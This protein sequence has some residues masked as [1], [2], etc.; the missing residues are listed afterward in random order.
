M[1]E[2]REDG[3]RGRAAGGP[4]RRTGRRAWL[5]AACAAVGLML[6][7][8]PT[9]GA[10]TY[11]VKQCHEGPSQPEGWTAAWYGSYL[12]YTTQCSSSASLGAS[13]DT[14]RQHPYGDYSTLTFTAAPDTAV[15]HVRA[16]REA[17]SYTDAPYG[18]PL[19]RL[20]GDDAALEQFG[21]GQLSGL[22]P[23]AGWL[24]R[25]LSAVSRVGL[26]VRCG[27]GPGG[28]CPTGNVS[29][30]L[31]SITWTMR[32]V[33]APVLSGVSGSLVTA[34][35]LHGRH[36]VS[37][38]ATDVGSGVYRVKLLEDGAVRQQ[39]VVD[40]NGGYCADADTSNDDPYE[41][42]KRA[43]CALTASGTWS[44]D[45]AA[46]SD[47]PHNLKVQFEDAAGNVTTVVN[48][49]VVAD[50]QPP[51][52][53]G[54]GV[55]GTAVEGQTLVCA[56]TVAGQSP[57]I[58]YGWWRTNAD[59]SGGVRIAGADATT[60]VLTPADIGRKV[61]CEVAATDLGGTTT[62]TSALTSGPF[63]D[64]RLVALAPPTVGAVTV[65]GDPVVGRQLT[66]QAATGGTAATVAV[67]WLRGAADGS[68]MAPIPGATGRAY[69]LVAADVGHR[70]GCVVTVQNAAGSAAG[71]S[72]P[73]D[74]GTVHSETVAKDGKDGR[75]GIGAEGTNRPVDTGG[76]TSTSSSGNDR[77][78]AQ[79]AATND[80]N[81]VP[82]VNPD[83]SGTNGTPVDPD[84]VLSVHFQLGAGGTR[85]TA[86]GATA[87][88][89]QR[90]RIRGTIRTH[91]G[92][93]IAGA[94]L[95]LAQTTGA[96]DRNGDPVWK[97]NGGTVSR[98]DGSIL[99]FSTA[100]GMNRKLRLVYFPYGGRVANRGSNVLSL[101]VRQDATL[102][103]SK[104]KLRNRQTLGFS[105][106]VR[107]VLS[108]RP[109]VQ[110]QVKLPAGWSTF[111]Q[112]R[113][114]SSGTFRAR[115]RFLRTTRR[116][117]Y[118][119]RV[120]VVPAHS[121]RYVAATSGARSVVVLP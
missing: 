35:V 70:I 40:A 92:R 74:V 120:R 14:T 13:W 25:D 9:A 62:V 6:A 58:A 77:A 112:A 50:N 18:T 104:R 61:L 63:S 98:E 83:A 5:V 43:P 93:P 65:T 80:L 17:R 28:T 91:D 114:S 99:T 29:Y 95:Y 55:E 27:G 11:T 51:V 108:P 101:S 113:L 103:L 26:E 100:G 7:A 60:Y 33:H 49:E 37:G 64:G 34:P 41:F 67:Q 48:R 20:L 53:S 32:D 94:K 69:E 84:A 119:F 8:A 36:E 45:T 118:R 31:R 59:G 110:L 81:V 15:V 71:G 102:R 3:A 2:R 121:S 105:G 115:Y 12:F 52:V 66:C 116:T 97:L 19:A 109:K 47:G 78:A 57:Q 21:Y 1:Q 73:A 88:F 82:V 85:R 56:A 23:T 46:M 54:V 72:D 16:W 44:L 75:D 87:R 4:V 117:T 76:S 79:A 89:A 42:V 86:A 10:G 96:T 107:G 111:K 68:G 22:G 24:D 90:L 106:R 30:T 39:T 38:T